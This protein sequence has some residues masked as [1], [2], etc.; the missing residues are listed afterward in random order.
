VK[1]AGRLACPIDL[2]HDSGILL[3]VTALP[4]PSPGRKPPSHPWAM[5]LT[6]GQFCVY[7]HGFTGLHGFGYSCGES[8]CSA[9][10]LP[11]LS[12]TYQTNCTPLATSQPQPRPFFV[13]TI[14]K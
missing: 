8:A 2:V 4:T 14:W 9:P 3:T 11:P 12:S 5:R 7:A 13:S 10:T 6:Q 1:S